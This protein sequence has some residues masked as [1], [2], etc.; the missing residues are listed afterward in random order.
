MKQNTVVY[1][2]CL[3][4]LGAILN[5][6][7]SFI[8]LCLHLPIFM[9]SIGTILVS[10]VLGV[11]YGILT[12]V[13]SSLLAGIIFDVYALYYLPVQ[14]IIAILTALPYQNKNI[15]KKAFMI[16]VPASLVGAL[17]TAYVFGGITSSG[18]SFLVILLS[19]TK[20]GLTAACF[21]V[22]IAS[23]YL[24]KVIALF[25]VQ[26]LLSRSFSKRFSK[27]LLNSKH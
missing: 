18:S 23:D 14:I 6:A 1:F 13:I 8:A 20:I 11:K 2:Q 16:S 19:K 22:Q 27:N 10:K 17:I 5:I 25:L 7:G 24:D 15:F 21:I 12:G 26:L 3:A 9:D 4:S